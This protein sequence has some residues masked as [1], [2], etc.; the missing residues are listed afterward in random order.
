MELPKKCRL[1]FTASMIIGLE[2]LEYFV[3]ALKEEGPEAVQW[4]IVP[5][6]ICGVDCIVMVW[7]DNIWAV[8]LSS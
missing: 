6:N 8:K 7:S 3:Q 4:P 1:K 5:N 2:A